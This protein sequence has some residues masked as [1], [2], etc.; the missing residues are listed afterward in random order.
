MRDDPE[1]YR[2]RAEELRTIAETMRDKS[3]AVILKRL[4]EENDLRV[5]QLDAWAQNTRQKANN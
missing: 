1:I 3:S 2:H 5:R 4:A